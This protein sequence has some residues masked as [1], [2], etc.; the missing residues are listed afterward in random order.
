MKIAIAQPTYLPWLG[1]FDLLDQVDTFVLLDTVQF[2]KQSW[3]Q[4]NR[5]KTPT[6]LL[7]LTVPVVFRGRLGQRIVDVEIREADFWRDHLRAVELNYRRAPFFAEYFPA[8]SELL[9]SASSS[10]RLAELNIGLLRW[11]AQAL[12]IKTPIVRSSELAVDGK[13]THLL[14]EICS[15]LGAAT[16]VSPLG[17][18]DYLLNE[19]PTLTSRGVNV[20]FQH[21]DHPSYRQL[22]PPFLAHASALDLLFN[23]GEASLATVRSGRRAPFSPSEVAQRLNEKVGS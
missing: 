18:A 11:L 8:L 15:L 6:G 4:R 16:Y 1:Y 22:F 3:Q 12:G 23:E 7:W 20:V 5:I 21:Y 2:E 17:S 14:A 19:L 10:L 9:P 13:R